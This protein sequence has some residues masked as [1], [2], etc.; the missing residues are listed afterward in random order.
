MPPSDAEGD[1][2]AVVDFTEIAEAGMRGEFV[3]PNQP[4]ALTDKDD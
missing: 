2:K 4:E 1:P 3:S